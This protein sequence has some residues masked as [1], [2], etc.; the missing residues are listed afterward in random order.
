MNWIKKNW[1]VLTIGGV[2][3]GGLTF[4]LVW[5]FVLSGNQ[6]SEKDVTDVESGVP[7]EDLSGH[8]VSSKKK[9]KAEIHFIADAP[10]EAQGVFKKFE[11]VLDID[12]SLESAKITVTVN[13]GSVFT[14]NDLR[15]EHL[16]GEDFFHASKYPEIVFT[17]ESIEALGDSKYKAVGK[18]DFLG[19]EWDFEFPFTFRGMADEDGKELAS[20]EGSFSFDHSAYGMK[21]S[22]DA[23][24]AD[25][26]FYVDMIKGGEDEGDD[27]FDDEFDDED[28]WEDEDEGPSLPRGEYDDLLDKVEEEAAQM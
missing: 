27:E 10:K 18:L 7:L 14:D 12:G 19:K 9:G 1:K 21:K 5:K 3:L 16:H 2:L 28:D 23:D 4:F 13:A 15:D 11:A 24:K 26:S 20:F 6:E 25:I 22:G 8:Y 17:S